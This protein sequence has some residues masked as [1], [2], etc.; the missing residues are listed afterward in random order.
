MF[1]KRGRE[2]VEKNLEVV[3]LDDC[4]DIF[5]DGCEVV[6]LHLVG[7]CA[8]N[9]GIQ[10]IKLLFNPFIRRG[11]DDGDKELKTHLVDIDI[12]A[13]VLLVDDLHA[14]VGDHLFEISRLDDS[15]E[16]ERVEQSEFTHQ[17]LPP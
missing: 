4:L 14:E 1:R 3:Q 9:I 10:L 15:R 5:L 7:L 6:V 11:A 12:L 16:C 8:L 13:V 2:P 17:P